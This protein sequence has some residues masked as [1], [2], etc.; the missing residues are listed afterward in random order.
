M[1]WTAKWIVPATPMEDVC[2]EFYKAF[3]AKTVRKATLTVTAIGVYEAKLNGK[4]ISNYVLAPGWT[5]F[6]TRLQYQTYDVTELVGGEN[7]LTILVGR[8]WHRGPWGSIRPLP[9]AGLLAELTIESADGTVTTIATDE[10]W[11]VRESFV[12]RSEL[13]NGEWADARVENAPLQPV[14][15]FEKS[16]DNLIP[17]EGEIICEQERIRPRRI[18]QTPKGETVVDFGQEVTGYVEFTVTAKAGEQVSIS[19]AEVLDKEGN[20]YTENYRSAKARLE[21]VCRDGVQTY[22]PHLTFFGFRYIR[23][24]AFPGTPKLDDFTAILVSSELKRTG[25]MRCGHVMLNRLYENVTWGQRGN[26]LDI[27]TDCPQRDER[28]G[29][30]GDVQVFVKTACYNY[31]V[32]KFFQKW[33]GD[34]A[35]DQL[36]SGAVPNFI[37]AIGEKGCSAAWGDVA[38]IVPWQLYLSYGNKDV[39]ARQMESMKAWVRY[40]GN[41]TKDPYLWTGHGHFGD[42][43]GLDAPVGSYKGSTREDFIAS[44]FYAHCAGLLA[45]VSEILGEDPAEFRDLREKIVAKFRATYPEYQT[46]TECVLALVFALTP[47]PAATAAELAKRVTDCGTALQTGFVGTPYILYALS[48]NGYA[49]LAYDLLLREAYP[50]WLY[51]IK[52]GA[53]T[54]WEH[55]DG[56]MENG[57]FWSADM[58]S[59][60]HYAYGSVMGWVYEEAAGIRPLETAPGYERVAIAPKPDAR[61]GWLEASVETA[62][63]TVFSGWYYETEGLRYEIRTPVE[64]EVTINGETKTLA[65]GSY[66]FFA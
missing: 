56:I 18:F 52:K 27:P 17:Q 59:F 45:K 2:P 6:K 54:V 49:D 7:E 31:D 51:P 20:F 10:S 9:P 13:Y 65:P 58:N 22:K 28:L 19:H 21:Y 5:S 23:L 34:L 36:E 44:A 61:L 47:D 15:L 14:V 1:N 55:W 60:N 57:D 35:A 32:N 43:L 63:G 26:F 30:T 50:S 53:T 64:A 24:D 39:L 37:P 16:M 62:Y 38:V 29:W 4:R 66:L 40:I 12:R 11:Q 42:W 41:D 3:S 8:G 46:Q 48:Q 25:K 33:L